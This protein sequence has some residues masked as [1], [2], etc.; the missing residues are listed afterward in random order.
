MSKRLATVAVVIAV[1]GVSAHAGTLFRLEI[2]PPVAAG[3][4]KVKDL[5][6]VGKKAVLAVRAVV[7][8]DLPGVQI[9]GTAE[10]LV[11]GVRQSVSLKLIEVDR[12]EAIYLLT[13]QWPEAGSWVLHL[14]GSCSK[15]KAEAA[16]LVPM[17]GITAVREKAEVL[18]EPATKKQVDAALSALARPQS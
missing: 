17:K 7:C 6:T 10:G 9:T 3:F 2:G 15:P 14:K 18:R 11:N 4:E 13:Y 12:A 16:T 1:A 5:K 8:D